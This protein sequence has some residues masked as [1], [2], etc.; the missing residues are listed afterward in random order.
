MR[1]IDRIKSY[2][3]KVQS[4]KALKFFNRI[5]FSSITESVDAAGA[6][7]V[8]KLAGR[9]RPVL[10]AVLTVCM[11]ITAAMSLAS[12]GRS[13]TAGQPGE[14]GAGDKIQTPDVEEIEEA[15][16]NPS[17]SVSDP[18]EKEET[19]HV[20]ADASGNPEE[21]K[22]TTVL[23][24]FEKS[25]Y[26]RDITS[27]TEIRNSKGDEEFYS[28]DPYLMWDNHG[29][30]ITYEG[31]TDQDLPVNVKVTYYLDGNPVTPEEIA[32]KTGD[33]RIRFE[34]A[35]HTA[36]AV[37][38][39]DAEGKK[40]R[41]A[42]IV[43][44]MAISAV[45]LDEEIFSDIEVENGRLVSMDGM[46]AAVG[47]AFPGLQDA[48]RLETLELTK[49]QDIDFPSYVE[50][51]AHAEEFALDFTATIISGGLFKDMETDQL[52]DI[53][54]LVDSM[55]D[56][57]EASAEIADG[58]SDLYDGSSEFSGYLKDFTKAVDQVSDGAGSL[59]D[60]LGQVNSQTGTLTQGAAALQKG[61]ETLDQS[62]SSFDSSSIS[63][64]GMS[65]ADQA[66]VMAAMQAFAADAQVLQAEL[67]TLSSAMEKVASFVQDAAVYAGTVTAVTQAAD[68]ALEQLD[69]ETMEAQLTQ[70]AG[71][72]A[73]TAA[74]EAIEKALAAEEKRLDVMMNDS[75]ESGI[76][77]EPGITQEQKEQILADMREC[78]EEEFS[79]TFEE[80][81]DLSGTLGE[82]E[83]TAVQIREGF[84]AIPEFTIPEMSLDM[85]KLQAALQDMGTQMQTLTAFGQSLA[86]M[87]QAMS[88][89]SASMTQLK[90][91]ISQLADGSA[92]LTQ[93]TK[94]FAEGI[95]QITDGA[96]RLSKGSKQLASSGSALTDGYGSLS[97]GIKTLADG[98]REFDE[99][100]IQEL[101]DLA[102]PDLA[103]LA[104]RI[105]ALK[106]A[107]QSFDSF[108]GLLE[109]Q[110]G[111][112][113]FI[114]ETEGI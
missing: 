78:L 86:G 32:G 27:L 85:T 5:R 106:I 9:T 51:T 54:D 13:E 58:A 1:W 46:Q 103:A 61:L 90:A 113:K 3:D 16:F 55:D 88:G 100:A 101:T 79:Q 63:S 2:S 104:D 77:S 11:M 60:G 26:L 22:V 73:G 75:P 50:I 8:K 110:K 6:F 41:I 95:R 74:R 42:S 109:G 92:Q 68:Q 17:G 67:E 44:F 15:V 52:D 53:D 91:A 19:V 99:E 21:T 20:K 48:L 69:V 10:V 105:R 87:G 89:I 31:I 107:D 38:V 65:E 62:L 66:K 96:A 18:G 43:P 84:A 37:E 102:G 112:V 14:N 25:D 33:V 108:G 28:Q 93:G 49:D 47:M 70:I 72:Q 29:E 23:K 98:L 80:E 59:S 111:S 83:Q 76:S 30:E 35:N 97:K 7:G 39:Q 34:Y 36:Q 114:I 57:K 81:I 64:S 12:C 82:L 71:A 56:L 4:L 40:S 94:A 45:S 24:D